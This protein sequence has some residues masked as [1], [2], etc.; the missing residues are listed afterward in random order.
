MF[1]GKYSGD[2]IT[3]FGSIEG[4]KENG[5]TGQY[6][7]ELVF[8][9]RQ[10]GGNN[11]ERMRITSTGQVAINTTSPDC[12]SIASIDHPGSSKYAL[13]ANST[14]TSGTQYHIS[15]SRGGT[16]AG[17]ITSNSAT[18]IAV[19]N[20]S[21]ERLKDKYTRTDGSVSNVINNLRVRQSLIGMKYDTSRC[22]LGLMLVIKN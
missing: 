21:D 4:S 18:T 3:C 15:F 10:H 9:T 11:F 8:K 1:S 16:Q 19:N 12:S 22:I 14:E 2:N 6:G 20:A 17:Y 5:T 13:S 7:T